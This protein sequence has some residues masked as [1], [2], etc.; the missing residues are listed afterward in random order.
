MAPQL[1][2]AIAEVRAGTVTEVDLEEQEIGEAGATQLADVLCTNTS[3]QVLNLGGSEIGRAEIGRA[4]RSAA[5]ATQLATR[6][7]P[8][9]AWRS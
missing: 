2:R 5:G 4:P 3:V 7:A 1:E 8:T 9:P 6:W